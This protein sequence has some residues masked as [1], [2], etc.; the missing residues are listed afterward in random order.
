M[1]DL[2]TS[3]TWLKGIKLFQDGL[4]NVIKTKGKKKESP[5]ELK[6]SDLYPDEDENTTRQIAE[7]L[8][9]LARN[10]GSR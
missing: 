5:G 9:K 10:G 1:T 8:G 2:E 6:L 7:L 4:Y 3:L